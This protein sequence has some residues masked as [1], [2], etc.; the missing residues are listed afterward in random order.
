MSLGMG[1]L[2]DQADA[3]R[4]AAL[5]EQ[6]MLLREL[7]DEV[8]SA[9]SRI[10]G[11]GLEGSAL[12]TS[13]RSTSERRYTARLNELTGDLRLAW[14]LIDEAHGAVESSIGRMKASE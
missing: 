8:E 6:R 11:G 10:V 9:L 2:D 4:L 7:G 3:E 1:V 5:R 14:R 12:G 13:W